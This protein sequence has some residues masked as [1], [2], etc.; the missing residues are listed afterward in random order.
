MQSTFI[1]S[2]CRVRPSMI[3]SG[4]AAAAVVSAGASALCAGA[5][6]TNE[7]TL[8]STKFL[9]LMQLSYADDEGMTRQWDMVQRKGKPRV[10]N[11]L[12]V[13]KSKSTQ[14]GDEETLLTCQFRPPMNAYVLEMPAAI[15]KDSESI[16]ECAVKCIHN[17]TGYG[18]TVRTTAPSACSSAGLTNESVSLVICDVN[19]DDYVHEEYITRRI[20]KKRRRQMTKTTVV[21]SESFIPSQNLDDGQ[22]IEVKRVKIRDL[23]A[24]IDAAQREGVVASIS[25]QAIAAGLAM[26][27]GF[28][29]SARR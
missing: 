28:G 12:P 20:G 19:L 6:V 24:H 22:F 10:V 15:L 5:K 9:E 11:V 17:E 23:Q 26:A 4:C 21:N 27:N 29:V 18:A 7:K 16:E 8:S 13:L 14:P 1:R 2:L 25:L 3:A